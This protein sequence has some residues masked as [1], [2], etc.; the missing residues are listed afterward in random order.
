VTKNLQKGAQDHWDGS[1]E[2]ASAYY[3]P[4]GSVVGLTVL[5]LQGQKRTGSCQ[6][7]CFDLEI[8]HTLLKYLYYFLKIIW[9][10]I[11]LQNTS[12]IPKPSN[13]FHM[14]SIK[15]TKYSYFVPI[16]I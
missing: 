13:P 4:H 12:P 3:N 15:K 8:G 6:Q 9:T 2:R 16:Q 10:L 1:S 14:S 11:A 7:D 5:Q